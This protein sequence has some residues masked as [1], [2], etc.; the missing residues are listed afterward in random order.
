MATLLDRMGIDKFE[1]MIQ[2]A[3]EAGFGDQYLWG[4]EWWY[5]MEQNGHPEFWQA[6]K[7]LFNQ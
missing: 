5:W 1:T 3:K 6:A 2:T 7:Q 4:A